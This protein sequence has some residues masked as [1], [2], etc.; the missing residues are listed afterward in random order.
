MF[1]TRTIKV[2]L[3]IACCILTG[4]ALRPAAA[5]EPQRACAEATP[6]AP[7]TTLRSFGE[8]LI[9][10][11]LKSAGILSLD[12]SV[13]G[14]ATVDAQL[15]PRAEEC[16]TAELP[17]EWTMIERSARHLV[18]ASPAPGSWFF[19]VA[20]EDPR[21]E[22]GAWRLRAGFAPATVIREEILL[23]PEGYPVLAR[24]LRFHAAGWL[25][26]E[27]QEIDP[28]PVRL[29]L[30]G[31]RLLVSLVMLYADGGSGPALAR[32]VLLGDN[33]GRAKTEEQEIDPDPVRV[34]LEGESVTALVTVFAGVK[35]EEQ[36]ID[37]DPVRLEL[38]PVSHRIRFR[39]ADP[40]ARAAV[41][42]WLAGLVG[43]DASALARGAGDG[44]FRL[45]SLSPAAAP[46]GERL[47]SDPSCR[48]LD[49]HGDTP[50]CA[51]PVVP[52]QEL[53]GELGNGWGDDADVFAFT[54][55][56]PHTVSFETTG[57][58]DTFGGLYD[59]FGHRLAADD[60]GGSDGNFRIVKT[61]VPGRY[62]LRLEGMNGA[63]GGY[64]LAVAAQGF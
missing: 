32:M 19:R 30:A 64:T 43:S 39:A 16:A 3:I 25:K 36:E 52:G 51:T 22:V 53:A 2:S 37:P 62:F 47:M 10:V 26:T 35:T 54:L 12:L 34:E 55:D 28:D 46:V 40:D 1:S 48:T 31:G 15:A 11:D 23:E 14:P 17:V 61:L 58:V 27:E 24:E 33:A 44:R 42:E 60:D 49:D 5:V 38:A 50:G 21:Q 56:E 4:L 7:G 6:A 63:E 57:E 20:A 41:L 45:L 29:E 8:E 9:R 13:P 18:L 59:R